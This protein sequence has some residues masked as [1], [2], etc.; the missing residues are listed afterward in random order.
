MRPGVISRDGF[1]GHD[2]R[3]LVEMLEEAANR[4]NSLGLSHAE[5]ADRM[6]YFLERAGHGLGTTVTVGEHYEVRAETARGGMPCPWGHP[7]MYPKVN[8]F[9]TNRATG[10]EVV[11]TALQVHMVR[12]HGFYEGRGSLFQLDPVKL[13][14]ALGLHGHTDEGDGYLRV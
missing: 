7:G 1:L 2:R 4:V 5:I 14:R 3:P 13:A 10:D 12:E 9:L 8:V 6:E 11:W